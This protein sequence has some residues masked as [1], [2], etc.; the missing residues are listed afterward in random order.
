MDQP[1]SGKQFYRRLRNL[2]LITWTVPPV[3]GLS[4]LMYIN[5]FSPQQMRDIL[6]SPIEPFFNIVWIIWAAWYLPR[7]VHA[8]CDYLDKPE[9][10]NEAKVQNLIRS[11]TF[12]YWGAFLCYLLSA[13]TSVML[14]AMGYTDYVATPSD[15]FRIHLIA[16]IVS[17]VVGL[18]IFFLILDLFGQVAG[19]LQLHKPHVTLKA[20]V[21][22]IGALVPL[23]IDTMLVLYYWTRTGYFSLETFYAWL[24]LELLAVCGSLIFV[25]SIGQSLSPLQALINN[26][27]EITPYQLSAMV[28][29]STD[30]LGVITSDYHKLLQELYEHR[31]QLE[32][33][34]QMRTQ[35]L[36]FINKELEA[37]AYSVSHDLRAPLRSINGFA[38]ILFENYARDLDEEGR[39]YL[40][41]IVDS[42]AR[43]SHIIDALLNLSRMSRTNLRREAVDLSKLAGTILETHKVEKNGRLIETRILPGLT[44]NAD[45]HLT[46]IMLENLL[47]NA[48]KF[49]GYRQHT[50]IEVGETKRDDLSCFYVADNGAGFDMRYADKL[51]QAFQRLHPQH[52]FE[53]VGIGLATVQRIINMH[54]GQIWAEGK[55]GEGATFYFKL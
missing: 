29:K 16:L 53:G 20:K 37:F 9:Q 23:L 27:N 12:Y 3:F 40:Q 49:T 11:F 17:I 51:F 28:P 47:N 26:E 15:W 10:A 43:M 30:E 8:V 54:G 25:H 36:T 5:M 19:K 45:K 46:H 34:V 4:A 1:L 35:E 52:E 18:P 41:R 33:Q 38:H 39:E 2:I 50:I 7:R 32:T 31:H 44:A 22:L 21:F 48:L 24:T 13:P 55:P 6:T 14:S 42:S